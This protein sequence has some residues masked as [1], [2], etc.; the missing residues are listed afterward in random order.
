MVKE[1]IESN[2]RK[3]SKDEKQLLTAFDDI[4]NI[5]ARGRNKSEWNSV[6]ELLKNIS[7]LLQRQDLQWADNFNELVNIVRRCMKFV[8][9]S[10]VTKSMDVDQTSL[11][12][13]LMGSARAIENDNLS[14][15]ELNE[16]KEDVLESVRQCRDNLESHIEDISRHALDYLKPHD[17]ILIW[18][19][20]ELVSSFIESAVDSKS[21]K[22][23]ITLLFS[24]RSQEAIKFQSRMEKHL[25]RKLLQIIV[26]GDGAFFSVM[27]IVQKVLIPV[28]SLLP[29]GSLR[30]P[31][32]TRSICLAAQAHSVPVLAL[33]PMHKICAD[34]PV[35][36]CELIKPDHPHEIK[37]SWDLVKSN[38][39]SLVITSEG[40]L[41]PSDTYRLHNELYH[42][43]DCQL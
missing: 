24:G 8:R 17:K 18:G 40:G 3:V 37:P 4:L 43:A 34:Y 35:D 25:D 7:G 6:D 42:Q 32:G 22:T 31:G 30:S 21:R 39:V 41:P 12:Q 38:L 23:P 33:C 16:L 36:E 15:S 27:P 9:E 11:V 20:S 10:K 2:R 5:V 1:D 28:T 29:D 19:Y 14:D 13:A 26:I